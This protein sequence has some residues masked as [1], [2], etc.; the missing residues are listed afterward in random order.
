MKFFKNIVQGY[1]SESKYTLDCLPFAVFYRTLRSINHVIQILRAD[2][3]T[4]STFEENIKNTKGGEPTYF[5]HPEN[6]RILPGSEVIWADYQRQLGKFYQDLQ[7]R[8]HA[9]RERI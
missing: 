3:M 6:K 9:F 8:T 4:N 2:L 1:D 5:V 7:A